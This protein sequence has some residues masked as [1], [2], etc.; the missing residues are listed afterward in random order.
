MQVKGVVNETSLTFG[1]MLDIVGRVAV[2]WHV[3]LDPDSSVKVRLQDIHLS[4]QM[5]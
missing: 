4:I 2:T 1:N 5:Y 3:C